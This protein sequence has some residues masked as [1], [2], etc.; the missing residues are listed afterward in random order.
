MAT[1]C[2]W[3]SGT[4]A[5]ASSSALADCPFVCNQ[6]GVSRGHCCVSFFLCSPFAIEGRH[7]PSH[8]LLLLHTVKILAVVVCLAVAF[9]P[10]STESSAVCARFCYDRGSLEKLQWG[11]ESQRKGGGKTM[12]GNWCRQETFFSNLSHLVYCFF[13]CRE[14]D[15][16]EIA[17]EQGL[18]LGAAEQAEPTVKK[19]KK[20]K[21]KG[22]E[23]DWLVLN[24]RSFSSFLSWCYFSSTG[25]HVWVV[26]LLLVVSA[27]SLIVMHMFEACLWLL[28]EACNNR[29]QAIQRRIG[30]YWPNVSPVRVDLQLVDRG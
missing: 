26:R 24:L 20:K 3:L 19:E 4:R 18:Q 1:S 27:L 5:R 2:P 30:D 23:D 16:E 25:E 14:N 22:K 8:F 7:T 17:A 12:T 15:L 28:V 11:W 9:R 6:L 10:D 29:P 13:N 21:K